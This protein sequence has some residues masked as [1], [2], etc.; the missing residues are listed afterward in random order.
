MQPFR[1]TKGKCQD[2]ETALS[3]EWLESNG[4]GGYAASTIIGAN[5]SRFHGL[6]TISEPDLTRAYQLLNSLE[7]IVE[8][9]GERFELSTHLYPD[10]VYPKGY[11][12]L[13]QFSL[14]PYPTF[15]YHVG[16]VQI[17]KS[18]AL[19]RGTNILAVNYR[20]MK[21]SGG[22]KL[23]V[24]PLTSCRNS[25]VL[26]MENNELNRELT[27]D[28]GTVIFKPYDHFPELHFRHNAAI[29][30]KSGCWYKDIE[31]AREKEWEA[32]HREDLYSPFALIYSFGT[33]KDAWFCLGTEMPAGWD[34]DKWTPEAY[35]KAEV[36]RRE[37]LSSTFPTTDR[38]WSYL[39]QG[40]E[41]FLIE[42]GE[43]LV[44]ICAGY[45]WYG[46]RMRDALLAIPGL[47]LVRGRY[48]EAA[49]YLTDLS[50][51]GIKDESGIS[52]KHGADIP[53]LYVQTVREYLTNTEDYKTVEDLLYS[54]MKGI[55]DAY[56][57]AVWPGISIDT[58][59]LI[60]IEKSDH[61]QTWMNV[62]VKGRAATPRF[63]KP[64]ELNALWYN[65]L[66]FIEHLARKFSDMECAKNCAEMA[67]KVKTAFNQN[68]WSEE[69]Y[70]YDCLLP[71][72]VDGAVRPNQLL[73]LS[74]PDAVLDEERWE[75]VLA[76]VEGQLKTSRGLRTLAPGH[77]SY[78]GEYT[79]DPIHP[80]GHFHQGTIWPWM[81]IHYVRACLR[82]RG[83]GR[84]QRA[85]LK[86]DVD[87][88]LSQ[89]EEAGLG[90]VGEFFDGDP[91][92]LARGNFACAASV[93]ALL[94][95][96]E[97]LNRDRIRMSGPMEF[98]LR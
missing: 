44:G 72:G 42:K 36:Q 53:L 9:K 92:H 78:V 67:S 93:S 63:G 45:P 31:Y 86:K 7:E 33:S 59:G 22:I 97:R 55:V 51:K 70:L 40:A 76:A 62:V 47:L 5:T 8:I 73:A 95:C 61:P 91:P 1:V 3:K 94:S 17:R 11:Q 65:A 50:A 90:L 18:V 48:A 6:L 52:V 16:E 58:D 35:F 87:A 38:N 54:L 68:Y 27:T 75:S 14:D 69:G 43:H 81:M 2:F 83:D 60:S 15:S 71:V 80:R 82:A 10:T 21:G 28:K 26:T 30:D 89:T 29:L 19:V 12:Y 66:K 23:T 46:Y 79:Q 57:T 25:D 96:Y 13:H 74:L 49:Q 20:L 88:I 32:D 24:R 41:H 39:W 37:M 98:V 85:K 34:T 4:M 56:R 84:D 77:A 64:V